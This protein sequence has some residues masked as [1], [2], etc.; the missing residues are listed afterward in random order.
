MKEL[1]IEVPEGYEIDKEKSTFEKIIF[2]KKVDRWRDK[3]NVIIQGYY[4]DVCSEIEPY[5]GMYTN[6]DYRK[7][8]TEKQAKSALA[9]A[10]ISQIMANDERFGGTITDEEWEDFDKLKFSVYRIGDDIYH[11][12]TKRYHF[13]AF[14]TNEQV[15]LFLNENEDLLRDY[16][17]L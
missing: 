7:F 5:H 11:N 2:K 16:F 15:E 4:M 14:H 12:V 10:R 1:K 9:M 13:I 6:E 8:A 17:M 3:E